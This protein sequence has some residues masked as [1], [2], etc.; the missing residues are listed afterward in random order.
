MSFIYTRTQLKAAINRLIQNK[1]GM[2]IDF[3]ETC[4]MAVREVL[5]DVDLRSARRKASLT[6]NLFNGEYDY[7]CPS[8]LKAYSIIDI[9]QQ[10]KREDG[11]FNLIPSREFAINKKR[12]DI[13]IDDF[14]GQRILKINSKVMDKTIVVSELDALDSGGGTWVAQGQAENLEVDNENFIKGNGALK[15]DI[16]ATPSF[17]AGII[18]EDLDDIDITDYINDNGAFFVWFYINSPT[19][20]N[21]IIFD[22]GNDGSNYYEIEITA[23]NDGS[24]FAAGWNLLRFDFRDATTGG[25]PDPTAIKYVSVYMEIEATKVSENDYRF[26]YMVLKVGRNA[27]IKYYSKY[28][29]QTSAGAYIENSTVDTDVLVADTDEF[30]LIVKKG[31]ELAAQEL[32][33]SASGRD[34]LA[35][36]QKLAN[37]FEKAKKNYQLKNPSEASIM[38]SEYYNYGNQ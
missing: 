14:N 21:S 22:I 34:P 38:T 3:G 17:Y 36:A 31:V 15:F 23:Q 32:D 19:G 33:I 2:L 29:W 24:A 18:N 28:G 16:G 7:A 30:N 1:S 6:P 20:L 8:D 12:G 35:K 5:G 9:P 13:A 26:D 25:T 27:D 10:A 11:E 4:N 37:D